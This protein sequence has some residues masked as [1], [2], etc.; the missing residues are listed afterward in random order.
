MPR[1]CAQWDG[2]VAR[3]PSG[4]CPRRPPSSHFP[5]VLGLC[6]FGC[7]CAAKWH[8][9]AGAMAL[10]PAAVQVKRE[11]LDE[12][13]VGP[14]AP[15]ALKPPAPGVKDEDEAKAADDAKA[16]PGP[17]YD[18][19]TFEGQ[20]LFQRLCH[21]F[22]TIQAKK[23]HNQK[24]AVLEGHWQRMRG[25]SFYPFMRLLLPHLD[26]KRTTYGL[27]ESKIA[28]YYAEILGIPEQATPVPSTCAPPPPP[29]TRP[30]L[31]DTN[32]GEGAVMY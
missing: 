23:G 14:S 18:P 4:G 2:A 29:K 16:Q 21:M 31:S 7:A 24:I 15:Q 17:K 20:Y 25:H 26:T 27:K 9:R 8:A 10:S 30:W 5:G 28:K 6:A 11:A 3:S 12:A 19:N 1:G 32:R 13:P 22:E